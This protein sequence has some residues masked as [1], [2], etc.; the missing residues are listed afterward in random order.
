MTCITKTTYIDNISSDMKG[1][2]EVGIRGKKA[3]IQHGT[4]KVLNKDNINNLDRY[5][6]YK[7]A[8]R[9]AKNY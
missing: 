2:V 3:F 5:Q 6:A 8:I 1:Y 4:C 9:I 7:I